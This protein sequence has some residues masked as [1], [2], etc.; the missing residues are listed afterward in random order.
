LRTKNEALPTWSTLSH[1]CEMSLSIRIGEIKASL[2]PAY[3]N[4]FR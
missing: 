1:I 2:V 3:A 4:H